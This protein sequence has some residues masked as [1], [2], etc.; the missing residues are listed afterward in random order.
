[1]NAR[2]WAGAALVDATPPP[3]L[4]MAGFAARSRP[5]AG[6]HDPLTVRAVAVGDTAIVCADV[7]GLHEDMCARIRERAQ[8]DAEGIVVA[9]LHT[10]GG[11]V[12]M[13][14]R[15]GAAVD[16]TY[17]ARLEEA[18]IRALDEAAAARRPAS[19]LFGVGDDPGVARNR[20]CPGGPVDSHLPVL[21]IRG[22]DGAWIAVVT[23]YACHP[24]VLGPNNLLWT[25]DYPAVVRRVLEAAHPGALALF[26]TGCA[27]D[28]NTGHT[29]HASFSLAP[30]PKRT[31]TAAQRIGTRIAVR[32]LAAEARPLV[33]PVCASSGVVR[34]DFARRE[35]LP[36]ETLARAW[37]EEAVTA[38][39][40][41]RAL[42]EAWVAWSEAIAPQPLVPWSARVT[43]LT[44]GG[45]A[46]VALPGEIFAET[47]VGIREGLGEPSAVVVGYAEGCPG[48]LPPASAF[49]HGGY[50]VDE[51]HRYY[52]MPA[53]FA[54]GASELLAAQAVALA[55]RRACEWQAHEWRRAGR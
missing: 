14:G 25:A 39:P 5:A 18:C 46:I 21:R 16:E 55:H 34:L 8:V 49:V 22:E 36:L 3:G 27:G 45:Q 24:V 13:D 11:P 53:T 30:D 44:W 19:L 6:A 29:A 43:A 4:A 20:R 32:A 51:A 37:R 47:A 38:D 28:A 54:P 48:Y 31:F 35:T 26:L 33:G 7:I 41:R 9:A 52:G 12:S 15:V 40:G 1:V 17:L 23:A 2:F 42:L 50:E 10:H